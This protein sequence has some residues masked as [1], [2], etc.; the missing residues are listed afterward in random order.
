[1]SLW[2]MQC[3]SIIENPAEETDMSSR[4][5]PKTGQ[6]SSGSSSAPFS[7]LP[8]L[9]RASRQYIGDRLVTQ[10]LLSPEQLQHA[11]SVQKNEP[12]ERLGNIL[13]RLG[14]VSRRC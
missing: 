5:I 9:V 2:L 1:M 8:R 7:N 14:M 4:I 12:D 3:T 10:G 11:L 6:P 13:L